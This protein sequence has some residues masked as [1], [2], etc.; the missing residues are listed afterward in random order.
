MQILLIRHGESEDDFLEKDYTGPTDLPLT[1]KGLQQVTKMSTRV[2]KE[3][4]PDFI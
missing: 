4:P 1:K 3:F 2:G